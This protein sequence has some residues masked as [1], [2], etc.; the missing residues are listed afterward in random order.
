[1]P[2]RRHSPDVLVAVPAERPH[3]E[4]TISWEKDST[5]TEAS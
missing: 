4:F 1:M 3:G 5:V 2:S